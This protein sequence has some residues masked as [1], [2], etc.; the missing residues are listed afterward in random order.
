MRVVA[1]TATLRLDWRMLIN[2]RTSLFRMA[3]YTDRIAG[4]AAAQALV[5]EGAMRIV[6]IAA[7]YQTFIHFVMEGLRKSGLHVSVAGVTELR[8]RNLEKAG[9]A[10]GFMNAMTTHATYARLSVCGALEVRMGRGVAPQARLIYC[11]RRCFGEAEEGF[12]IAATS[13][14]MLS[15]RPVAALARNTLAAMQHRKAGVRVLSE[16][17]VDLTV[18]ELTGF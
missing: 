13:L 1:R 9:L 10:S 16:L 5:L 18:T 7:I 2:K 11:F 12:Q 14:Y 17:L 6:T 8:L 4:D 15:A 3:L